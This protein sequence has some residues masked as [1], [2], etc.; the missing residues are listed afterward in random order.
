MMCPCAGYPRTR[1]AERGVWLAGLKP[2]GVPHRAALPGI[3]DGLEDSNAPGCDAAD[4]GVQ[5]GD[6]VA[7]EAQGLAE[8]PAVPS[9]G[10][11]GRGAGALD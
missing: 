2:P 10:V 1:D 3:G 4:E 8:F 5:V 7:E 9:L 6:G 11:V